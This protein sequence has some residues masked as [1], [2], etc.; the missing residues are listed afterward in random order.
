MA[1]K[2]GSNDAIDPTPG[3]AELS[4]FARE[5]LF[6]SAKTQR[7]LDTAAVLQSQRSRLATALGRGAV[8][9]TRI[10]GRG[11]VGINRWMLNGASTWHDLLSVR[12]WGR[13]EE[14]RVSLPRNREFVA[15]GNRMVSVFDYQ[16]TTPQA[17]LLLGA[18]RSSRYLFAHAPVQLKI[19]DRTQVLLD[20]PAQ[21]GDPTVMVTTDPACLA[22]AL[23]Y[24]R[25]VLDCSIPCSEA[26]E[27]VPDLTERQRQV[28]ALLSA[29]VNDEQI[30]TAIGVSVRTVRGEIA[31]AMETLGV[32][33]RFSLGSAVNERL[34]A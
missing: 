25:A 4:V 16:S 12:L 31:R 33:S 7:V 10:V 9:H 17:R 30:A 23:G 6:P 26:P 22:A 32:Q 28:V 19:V 15:A 1:P 34:R 14:L 11:G 24:W 13:V 18:E 2:P 5:P 20:G 29:D 3:E 8:S 21:G 27:C